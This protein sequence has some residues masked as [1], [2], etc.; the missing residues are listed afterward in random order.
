MGHFKKEIEYEIL[1]P[2]TEIDYYK[3]QKNKGIYV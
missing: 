3:S 2:K 1:N